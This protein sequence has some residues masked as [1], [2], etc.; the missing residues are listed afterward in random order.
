[1]TESLFLPNLRIADFTDASTLLRPFCVIKS[2][3][4]FL[5][6]PVSHSPCRQ[7]LKPAHDV[8]RAMVNIGQPYFGENID[9]S[10]VL[11]HFTAAL[12][13]QTCSFDGSRFPTLPCIIHSAFHS[14]HLPDICVG[15]DSFRSGAP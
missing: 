10:Y 2:F 3:T 9:L 8:K 5:S 4:S 13:F 1:M 12:V 7:F 6:L 15:S 14:N 11:H